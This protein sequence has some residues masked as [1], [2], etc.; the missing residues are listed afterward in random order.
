[1]FTRCSPYAWVYRQG[2]RQTD[3]RLEARLSVQQSERVS[4]PSLAAESCVRMTTAPSASNVL[5]LHPSA[6]A[7]ALGLPALIGDSGR[8]VLRD[9]HSFGPVVARQLMLSW[10]VCWHFLLSLAQTL[11][12][13]WQ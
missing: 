1:M 5:R 13:W 2:G 11:A 12:A 3:T 9:E 7:G 6:L 10:D 8:L 4:L